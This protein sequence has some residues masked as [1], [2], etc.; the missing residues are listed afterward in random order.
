MGHHSGR[1]RKHRAPLIPTAVLASTGAAA[2]V[3]AL[4]SG[5]T[6]AGF[7]DAQQLPNTL[8]PTPTASETGTPE[9][10]PTASSG[11]TQASDRASRAD[12]GRPSHAVSSLPDGA[13]AES[14]S[15]TPGDTSSA[16]ET[17]PETDS[18]TPEDTTSPTE[19]LLSTAT[20]TPTP[21]PTEDDNGNGKKKHKLPLPDLPLDADGAVDDLT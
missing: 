2:V 3:F 12:V 7:V 10:E 16:T 13:T 19:D 14:N 9:A 20:P 21:T 4:S 8:K 11:R 17:A 5:G 6:T 1:H 15:P 18:P